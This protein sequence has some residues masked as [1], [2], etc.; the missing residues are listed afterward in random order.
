M[1]ILVTGAKGQL[2]HDVVSEAKKR[3]YDPVGVD[4]AEMDITDRE[5]VEEVISRGD[6]DVVV[7]C[8]AWTAVDKG[9]EPELF[10]TVEAVNVL[11][12][13]YI[14]DVCRQ[15]DI[16]LMYFSTDYVFDGQGTRP[17]KEDDEKNPL[18]VY[19]LTKSEG[20]D[21]VMENPKNWILRISWVF[22][23]SGQNFIRTMVRLGKE[24]DTL[25]VVDDQIGLP[26]YTLDLAKLVVDMIETDKYGTYN[27][28]NSGDDYISWY[29]FAKEIFNQAGMK[30]VK[31]VPVG[32]DQY[33]AKA[34]RPT[35]SRLDLT[36]LKEAGFTPLPDWKDA[37]SRYLDTL[38]EAGEL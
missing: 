27:V 32:S 20:E 11:G 2:G 14:A 3:G 30:K 10:E 25:T 36:K 15:L 16:P 17:W 37:T 9:E 1:K 35:N 8:A 34:K 13:K 23:A 18:N 24:R 12:T 33:P 7:H 4:V 26:T 29:D 19:G 5:Q 28:C 21:F 38:R 31:V 22:G 6:Y